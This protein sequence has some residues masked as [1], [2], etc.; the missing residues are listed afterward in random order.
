MSMLDAR[1]ARLLRAALGF[2][3]VPPDEP[4]LKLLHRWLD[5]WRGIGDIVIGMARQDYLLHLT[6]IDRSTWRAT[7][8]RETKMT[9][10]SDSARVRPRRVSTTPGRPLRAVPVERLDHRAVRPLA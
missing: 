2:A 5:C 10:R 8:S 6:N 3:L 4:E 9:V 1:A 7:F